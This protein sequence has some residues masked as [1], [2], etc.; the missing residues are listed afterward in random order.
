MV[1]QNSKEFLSNRYVYSFSET[2]TY[3]VWEII[4]SLLY[5]W[6]QSEV[7]DKL[8][9]ALC[10]GPCLGIWRE[11]YMYC[12]LDLYS[13]L[14]PFVL[15]HPKW[16]SQWSTAPKLSNVSQGISKNGTK[17]PHTIGYF[18]Y[19]PSIIGSLMV[20]KS[21]MKIKTFHMKSQWN[22]IGRPMCHT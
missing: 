19:Y 18:S 17:S 15:I 3:Q 1:I 8:D 10:L 22:E 13:L 21:E 9:S 11:V 16:T 7:L 2:F 5:D 14:K 20:L 12:S 6:V 4:T